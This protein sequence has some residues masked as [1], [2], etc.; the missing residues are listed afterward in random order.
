MAGRSRRKRNPFVVVVAIGVAVIFVAGSATG[1]YLTLSGNKSSEELLQKGRQAL[2]AGDY[3]KAIDAYRSA[4]KEN[5][6][7]YSVLMSLGTALYYQGNK[8]E[9]AAYLKKALDL[10]PNSPE[11]AQIEQMLSEGQ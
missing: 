6:N 9:A 2:E 7:D 1:L 4:Y 3:A 11:K 5:P 8:K 10:Y